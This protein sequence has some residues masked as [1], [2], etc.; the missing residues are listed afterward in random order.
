MWSER[1]WATTQRETVMHVRLSSRDVLIN[2]KVLAD[3]SDMTLSRWVDQL[4]REAIDKNWA[5]MLV[6]NFKP[7]T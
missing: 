2:A 4:M 3:K 6:H 5:P 7:M 1:P